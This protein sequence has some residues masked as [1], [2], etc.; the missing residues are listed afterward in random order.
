MKKIQIIIL[1]CLLVQIAQAQAPN[2]S[3]FYGGTGDGLQSATYAQLTPSMQLGGV[4]SGFMQAAYMQ[5][6][7]G[8]QLGGVGD[9]WHTTAFEQI[10]NA[11]P[12]IGGLG[13]S[14]QTN[15]YEQLADSSLFYGAAGN[16]WQSAPYKQQADSA[17]FFGG[18]G[19]GWSSIILPLSPL[20]LNLLSFTGSIVDNAH[21][22]N[23]T[24]IQEKNTDYFIIEH[25][26][27]ANNFKAI[28]KTMASGQNTLE[29]NY[30]FFNKNPMYGNNFYRLQ[31]F[32]KDGK[33]TY[34]NVILLSYLGSKVS[35]NVYPNPAA[36]IINVSLNNVVLNA[37]VHIQIVDMSGKTVWRESLLHKQPSYAIDISKLTSG[38]Y[39]LTVVYKNEV[40]VIKFKKN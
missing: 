5:S 14:W 25:A 34:S 36:S 26:I 17:I 19:D 6:S 15:N 24:T 28:G 13:D 20:P 4:G 40:N 29:N 21:Q 7:T 22:L 31:I 35:I 38:I 39:Q 23:W 37:N 30:T 3:I 16:G 1:F 12:Y 32:D 9:A 2:N 8:V 18:S 33:Y 27:D 11:Y 10:G